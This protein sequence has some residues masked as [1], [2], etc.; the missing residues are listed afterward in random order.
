MFDR[1]NFCANIGYFQEFLLFEI[2][3]VSKVVCDF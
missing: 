3:L 2:I 1:G